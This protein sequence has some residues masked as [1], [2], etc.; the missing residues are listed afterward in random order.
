[1]WQETMV[2]GSVATIKVHQTLDA[3][4]CLLKFIYTGE[5]DTMTVRN[6]CT[7]LIY[8]AAQ[9]QY[10]EL[11]TVCEEE[12]IKTVN[13]DNVLNMLLSSYHHDLKGLEAASI[14]YIKNNIEHFLTSSR[15]VSLINLEK[16][17]LNEKE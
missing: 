11:I 5:I 15:V 1:V 8:L 3:Y 10:D 13:L 16:I 7:E 12:G 14:D 17:D 2:D 9:G 4:K 6:H